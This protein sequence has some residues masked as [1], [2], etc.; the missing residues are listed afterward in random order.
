MA[1]L[2]TQ[3]FRIWWLSIKFLLLSAF[4][5]I[6][7]GCFFLSI[8]L[9]GYKVIFMSE[10]VQFQQSHYKEPPTPPGL[11]VA[12]I[13]YLRKIFLLQCFHPQSVQSQRCQRRL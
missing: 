1:A 9:V 10:E 13:I 4:F 7:L 6:G 11:V 8:E 2:H 5:R 12:T 3:G